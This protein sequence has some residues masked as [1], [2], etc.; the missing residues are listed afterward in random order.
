MNPAGPPEAVKQ[1]LQSVWHTV[2]HYPDQA[3]RELRAKLAK[4]HQ[5]LP[6]NIL[7]GNGAAECIDLAL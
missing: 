5:V 4:R 1:A 7:V 6:D 3:V 2:I